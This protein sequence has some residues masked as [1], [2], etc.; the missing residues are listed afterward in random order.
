VYVM[1][2]VPIHPSV[3][4]KH[5]QSMKGYTDEFWHVSGLL[6]ATNGSYMIAYR[7][8]VFAIHITT[9][10]HICNIPFDIVMSM[11]NREYLE[12]TLLLPPLIDIITEYTCQFHYKYSTTLSHM[13]SDI[14][15]VI[16]AICQF[17]SLTIA[18]DN[19]HPISTETIFIKP[20]LHHNNITRHTYTPRPQKDYQKCRCYT[21]HSLYSNPA[22]V[23]L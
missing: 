18:F 12:D 1:S 23:L 19:T 17:Q 15:D 7:D 10:D 11:V 2:L 21:R 8:G 9:P 22:P 20:V 5:A 14:R 6:Y 16:R 3:A 13:T 4:I